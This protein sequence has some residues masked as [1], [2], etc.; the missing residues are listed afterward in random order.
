MNISRSSW[1][2]LWE[3]LSPNF[4]FALNENNLETKL[5]EVS[6]VDKSN[7]FAQTFPDCE[8]PFQV[9]THVVKKF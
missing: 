8:F 4:Q 3:I 1:T 9:L 7:S 6:H 2:V 5:R